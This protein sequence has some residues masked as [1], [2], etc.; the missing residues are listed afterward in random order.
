MSGVKSWASAALKAGD[1]GGVEGPADQGRLGVRRALR[2]A[3]HAAIGDARLGDPVAVEGQPKAPST[4][5]MSSSKRFE[6]L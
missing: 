3:G 4:A 1:G 2:G 5:E 6:T